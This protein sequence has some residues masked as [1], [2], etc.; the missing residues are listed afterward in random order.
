MKMIQ[1][2]TLIFCLLLSVETRAQ[3]TSL[4]SL[5]NSNG[6]LINPAFAGLDDCFSA[7]LNHRNQW[8]GINNSPVRNALTL[9]GR[10]A[11]NHGIGLDTRM[12]SAGLLQNFQAKFTY[13]YHLTITEKARLSFGISIGMIQQSLA[14]SEAIVS[15]VTDNALQ[16]GNQA[17][18]GFN[19]DA[20]IL[21]STPRLKIGLAVPQ[22]FARGLFTQFGASE[23]EYR[24]VQHMVFNASYDLIKRDNW[25]VSP[26]VLYRNAQFVGHQVDVGARA[27]WK[28]FF[29]FGVLYRTSYGVMALVDFNIKDKLKLAYGYGFGG[30]NL[31]GMSNGSHEIMVGIKL[32]RNASP[33][34]IELEEEEP[35][36]EI[37]DVNPPIEE[38]VEEDAPELDEVPEVKEEPIIEEKVTP[39]K[40]KQLINLDSLNN[41]FA[42][43][44]RLIVYELN[45]D[46]D[47]NSNNRDKVT[48]MVAELLTENLD[49][50]AIT[51]GHTC[52]I[53]NSADNLILSRK[54]AE[55]IRDAL[56]KR[57]VDANRIRIEYKGESQ[58]RL[59]NTSEANK[60][61][62]RR[63]Q[64]VFERN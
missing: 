7:Y 41:A 4:S 48:E 32:C 53:G 49:L 1:K 30:G 63:V 64:I 10:I 58:P 43:A 19:S 28:N 22:L 8:V 45:S 25:L 61:Q 46:E 39:V 11:G 29:G 16:A 17:A 6:Y 2:Y 44:D 62:N 33:L 23:T 34:P 51:I 26:S 35:L 14:F 60:A 52:D 54:R 3:Q 56:I 57:G 40:E 5:Y 13:A 27:Q 55:D 50:S 9:D 31:T 18:I 12:Y 47:I 24:L 38:N 36:P 21:L 20:G 42:A 15:D 37:L 59:P